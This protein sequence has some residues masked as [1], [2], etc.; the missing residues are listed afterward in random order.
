MAEANLRAT[1]T[2]L[3]GPALAL[4]AISL[5]INYVDRGNLSIAAPILKNELDISGTE[6]GFLFSAFSYT[7]FIFVSGWLVDRF[8]VNWVLAMGFV[9]WSLATAGTGFAEGF[10]TLLVARL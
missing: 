7:L 9:V 5:L 4:L 2:G 6:L 8:N 10:P 1:R 3:F